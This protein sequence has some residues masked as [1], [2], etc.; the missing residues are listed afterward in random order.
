MQDIPFC[1]AWD[2]ALILF[3]CDLKNYFLTVKTL[4]HYLIFTTEAKLLIFWRL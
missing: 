4:L 2:V 3:V 1:T